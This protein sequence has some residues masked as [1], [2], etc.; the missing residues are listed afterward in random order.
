M[1]E[2]ATVNELYQAMKAG[3]AD[4][5][6]VTN[7]SAF[8]KEDLEIVKISDDQIIDQIITAG[9]LKTSEQS[10]TSEEFIKFLTSDFGRNTFEEFGFKPVAQ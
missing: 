5:A 9:T 8:G 6:I 10:D 7:D 1:V 3:N 2:T 4:A